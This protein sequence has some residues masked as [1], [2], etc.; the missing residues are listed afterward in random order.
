[1]AKKKILHISL[2]HGG[3]VISAMEVYIRISQDCEHHICY[4]P[5]ENCSISFKDESLIASSIRLNK[6]I[7]IFKEIRT[8]Y[9]NLNPDY[10]HFHSSFAGGIGRIA[11]ADKK[12]KIYTPHCFSFERTDIGNLK[13][14]LFYIAEWL[15]ALLPT[16]AAGCSPRERDLANK[17]GFNIIKKDKKSLF[18]TNYS[19]LDASKWQPKIRSKKKVV[20]VGRLCDQK[21]P[22]FFFHTFE[23]VKAL[24]PETEFVW[25]GDGEDRFKKIF[26]DAGIK[27]TGWV[28]RESIIKI[29]LDT[30]LYFHTAAWEGN[31]MSLLEAAAIEM[32]ILVRDIKASESPG[33]QYKS[34]TPELCADLILEHF[35]YQL[36]I[37]N[38]SHNILNSVCNMQNQVE[39]LKLLYSKYDN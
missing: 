26:D 5:D 39:A 21:D 32:P 30:D 20:M 33:L 6:S 8:A 24:Y 38:G 34:K 18:L 29:L 1:M 25:I 37:I 13:K 12:N 16:T 22:L 4:L 28:N 7:T 19:D 15:L 36:D 11:L 2:A 3:G 10:V 23:K 35:Q 31:P 9:K 17:L 14:S 27:Y